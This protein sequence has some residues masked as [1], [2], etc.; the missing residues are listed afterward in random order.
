VHI[1]HNYSELKPEEELDIEDIK[2]AAKFREGECKSLTMEKSDWKSKLKFKCAFGHEF[3]ATPR[4]ILKGG[5]W[6][7][8][9]KRRSWNYV[10]RA[11]V[12]PFLQR[13][14]IPCTIRMIKNESIRKRLWN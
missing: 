8:E 7:P 12:D 2:D 13:F 14:G 10:A 5:H 1:Y 9:C 6:C 11:K 3:D 4:L